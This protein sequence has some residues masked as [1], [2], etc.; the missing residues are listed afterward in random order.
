MQPQA[1]SHAVPCFCYGGSCSLDLLFCL[2][3]LDIS[4]CLCHKLY[5]CIN[6]CSDIGSLFLCKVVIF[7]DMCLY[8]LKIVYYNICNPDKICLCMSNCISYQGCRYYNKQ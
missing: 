2:S 6:V 3:S 1:E 5:L 4:F 8:L 7:L